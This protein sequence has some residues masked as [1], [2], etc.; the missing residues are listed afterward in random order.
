MSS[1]LNITQK[2]FT[3]SA[4]S[5]LPAVSHPDNF[6]FDEGDVALDDVFELDL[7]NDQIPCA[8]AVNF[9]TSSP[10]PSANGSAALLFGSF[11]SSAAPSWLENNSTIDEE[12]P[13]AQVAKEDESS[14]CVYY[15]E[16]SSSDNSCC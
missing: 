15:S 11:T 7:S 14:T 13:L 5:R 16:T 3:E 2:S 12:I 1:P 6:V 9:T 8:Q 10:Y 4:H